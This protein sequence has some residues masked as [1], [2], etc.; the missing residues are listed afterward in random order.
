MQFIFVVTNTATLNMTQSS[1]AQF[2]RGPN[3][4]SIIMAGFFLFIQK[5]V[6]VDMH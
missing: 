1:S 6:P 4:F 3:I 2:L 5:C